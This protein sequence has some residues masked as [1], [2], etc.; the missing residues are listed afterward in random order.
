MDLASILQK[1]NIFTADSYKDTDHFYGDFSGFL[2]E[3]G[4]I[5]DK[6]AIK[7]L[8][9]KRETVH[10]TAIGKGAASPHIY[11]NEFQEFLCYLA[12]IKRG[13]E[14]KAPDGERVFLIFLIMSTDRDVGLHLKTLA[15]IARLVDE[16]DLVEAIKNAQTPEEIYNTILEKEKLI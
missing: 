16:T 3:R 7:R 1:E 5:K 9:I 2:K 8:F 12:F 4:V 6:E 14:Y 13:M 15:R 10:S 11:S